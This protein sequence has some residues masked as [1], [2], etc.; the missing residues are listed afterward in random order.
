MVQNRCFFTRRKWPLDLPMRPLFLPASLS[1]GTRH[2]S[3]ISVISVFSYDDLMISVWPFPDC[4]LA[5]CMEWCRR[6]ELVAIYFSLQSLQCVFRL[7]KAGI[8]HGTIRADSFTVHFNENDASWTSHYCP[9][10]SGGWAR[11]GLRLRALHRSI[12]AT[13]DAIMADLH[14]LGQILDTMS[15]TN[16][17]FNSLLWMQVKSALTLPSGNSTVAMEVAVRALEGV[18]VAPDPGRYRQSLKSLLTRM[19]IGLLS[20]K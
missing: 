16:G 9:D 1:F 20:N 10:G 11:R 18:L 19:Q 4:T 13:K 15:T 12:A 6:D 5:D 17:A 8:A 7:H 3:I 14:A 2:A